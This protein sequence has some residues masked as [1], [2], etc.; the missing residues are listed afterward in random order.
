MSLTRTLLRSPAVAA[1][2]SPHGID[3]YLE[4][5]H[6]L[7]TVHEVRA[8][9]TGIRHETADVATLTLRPT[10][11]W[12]GHR[13]GQFVQLGV[14]IDGVRRTRCFSISSSEHRRDAFTVTV[15]AHDEGLVSRHLVRAARPGTVVHLSQAEGGFTLPDPR[16]QRLVMVSGGS[17]ITPV[18]AMLRT[19]VDEGYDGRVTF[20]HYSQRPETTI[21]RD[22]LDLLAGH[23]S[24]D[25]TVVHTRHGGERF[26][27]DALTAL[28]P[29]AADVD[30]Y[31]CGPAGL[32]E[33]VG[34]AYADGPDRLRVEYFKTSTL[35]P[36]PSTAEG[37]VTFARSGRSA[38]NTGATLLEQ[39]EAAGLSPEYGCRMGICFT[40]TARRREGSTRNVVTGAES[41]LPDEDVQLCVS[42]PLGDCVVDV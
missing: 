11:T 1:L 42:T 8:E 19:L 6:P 18:M 41:S 10:D 30:A 34:E 7:W 4:L 27:P 21:Y 36:D 17:G 25:L 9:V 40:C 32:V 29:D 5:L 16:P 3:R 12:R 24:V 28:A 31:A 33:L 23:P 14:E 22:E 35:R 39:A 37:T 2:T 13:A 38:E 15:R 26:T 20:L